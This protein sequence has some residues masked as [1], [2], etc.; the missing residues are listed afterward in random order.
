M[1]NKRS[2]EVKYFKFETYQE[3]YSGIIIVFRMKSLLL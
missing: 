3:F 2:F 1:F